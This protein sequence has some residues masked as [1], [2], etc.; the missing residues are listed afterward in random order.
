MKKTRAARAT[1]ILNTLGAAS[2]DILPGGN[3]HDRR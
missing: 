1:R 3:L 2:S